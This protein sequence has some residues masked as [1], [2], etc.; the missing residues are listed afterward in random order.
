MPAVL[1]LVRHGAIIQVSGKA[2]IGQIDVPLSEEGVEQAWALREW[3]EPIRFS[4]LY[5]SDLSRAQRT[6]RIIAGSGGPA[7]TTLP[8]LREINL[9]QWE[10]VP[11]RDIEQRFPEEY[12]ARGRD[13]VNWHP[14][15]GESFHDCGVRVMKILDEILAGAQGNTLL[16]AHAGVNRVI[17]CHVLGIP[18]ANLH[19]LGQD[20]GCVNIIDFSAARTRVKLLN[21]T[22]AFPQ[23]PPQPAG[24]QAANAIRGNA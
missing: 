5:S 21:Y 20:Y 15:E 18:L 3:L 8:A 11:F 1:Y 2:Y 14:P 13:M 6:C 9:G 16:V 22:P 23:R 7:I 4:H 12:A 17:L 19:A 24:L 10:G